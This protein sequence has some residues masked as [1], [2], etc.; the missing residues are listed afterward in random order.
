MATNLVLLARDHEALAAVAKNCAALGAKIHSLSGELSDEIFMGGAI[1]AALQE[2]AAIDV[3]I[4]NAGV[5]SH[6]AVQH[7]DLADWQNTMNINFT[8]ITYLSRHILPGMIERKSGTIINISSISGRNTSAGSAIYSASKHA[9]NGFAGCM[10]EDVRD[11]GIKISTIMPGFVDTELTQGLGMS[12]GDMIKP[13]DVADSVQ[14]VLSAS[15]NCCPTEIV[16]R[17]QLRP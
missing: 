7:A 12:A 5:A 16:L 3:L 9:L 4:N 13:D 11:Y 14:Y 6:E 8:A 10:Y 15:A 1:D 17:P 2:F